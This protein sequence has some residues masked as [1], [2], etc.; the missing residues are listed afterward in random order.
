MTRTVKFPAQQDAPGRKGINLVAQEAGLRRALKLTESKVAAN[1]DDWTSLDL[2]PV[3][4]AWSKEQEH[5]R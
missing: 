5:D 1:G 4:S 2:L 3:T